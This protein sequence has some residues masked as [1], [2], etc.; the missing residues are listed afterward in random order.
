MHLSVDLYMLVVRGSLPMTTWTEEALA[1]LLETCPQCLAEWEVAVGPERAAEYFRARDPA[2][3]AEPIRQI[4]RTPVPLPDDDEATSLADLDNR[5][6]H[7]SIVLLTRRRAQEDLERLLRLPHRERVARIQSAQSRYRSRA[8]AEL[9]V[10]TSRA[11]AR[12]DPAGAADLAALVPLTLRWMP[13]PGPVAWV[14]TLLARA[15][16]HHANA[17]REAGELERAVELFDEL[18]GELDDRPLAAAGARA[19]IAALERRLTH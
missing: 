9:L 15:K 8:L 16:A 7:Y 3:S 4:V 12:T 18:R 19:E 14:A 10:E 2:S 1:H 6:D 5:R 17:L 11:R 13:D